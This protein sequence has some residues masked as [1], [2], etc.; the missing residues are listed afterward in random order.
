M[1]IRISLRL[2]ASLSHR[3]PENPDRFVVSAGT[4]VGE[5]LSGF[6]I[7]KEEAQLVF[8]NNK[9]ADLTSTLNDGDRLGVFPPV[10]G[11]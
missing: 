3:M 2:F 6:G 11:G 8:I 10:G 9:R 1:D 4:T 5:V 7:S